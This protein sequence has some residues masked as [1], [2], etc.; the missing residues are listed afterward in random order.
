MN[1]LLPLLALMFCLPLMA[2]QAPLPITSYDYAL[3]ENNVS[4]IAIGMGALN[5]T[6]QGDFYASY[7]NPALLG[8]NQYSAF[9]TSFR[10]A[11]NDNLSFWQ[12]TQLSNAL[13]EK[14]FKYFSLLTK[15][16]AWTYQPVASVHISEFNAA[17]DSSRYYDYQLD[18]VQISLAGKDESWQKISAGLNLKYLTGRLVYL[19]EHKVG[20]MMVRDA[21]IDDKVKGFSTDLG[22]TLQEGNFIF[23]VVAYDLF[24]RLYWENYSSKRIQNR[25]AL[26]VQYS[27]E[28]LILTGGVQGK[29]SKATDT[30]YHFGLQ[31]T[32]TWNAPSSS[33]QNTATQSL[34]LRLGLY[35]HD[36]YGTNNIN[37]TFGT[38]YNYNIFRFD[39]SLNNQGMRIRDSEYLFSLGVGLP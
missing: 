18:K 10:L 24:S 27:G 38:G 19:R 36:F 13:R 1:R 6:Y 26:G 7:S 9:V 4:P 25:M 21:F 39:F 8:N 32:W 23:G 30:T 28:T 17:M 16:A 37:F 31:N 33:Y 29:L 14:Q 34:V 35:S 20:T 12:A 11:N 22:L 5:V 3:P 15:Q 2:Q